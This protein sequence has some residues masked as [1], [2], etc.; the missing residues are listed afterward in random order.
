M[1][2]SIPHKSWKDVSIDFIL[3]LP[4]TNWSHNSILVVV[5]N[6]F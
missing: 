4:R 5:D 2:L 6:F 1:P 3:G